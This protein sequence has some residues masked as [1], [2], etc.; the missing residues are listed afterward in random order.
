[1]I[2][3]HVRC[4]YRRDS[5][6]ENDTSPDQQINPGLERSSWMP[7]FD[8]TNHSDLTGERSDRLNGAVFWDSAGFGHGIG[9]FGVG[10][11]ARRHV[12]DD[13]DPVVP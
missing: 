12:R 7:S 10:S 4:P 3:S 9:V 5:L 8:L 13:P 11:G 2:H 6:T 1:M